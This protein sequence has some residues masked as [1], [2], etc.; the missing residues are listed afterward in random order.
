ARIM[1]YVYGGDGYRAG[2]A[3]V[4]SDLGLRDY[5]AQMAAQA[6]AQNAGLPT[7][8][9]ITNARGDLSGILGQYQ[10]LANDGMYRP[11]EQSA[12][13]SNRRQQVNNSTRAMQQNVNAMMQQRGVSGNAGINAAISMGG[14]FEGAGQRGNQ[15]ADL[16]RE[17]AQSRLTGME[18]VA[19]ISGQMAQ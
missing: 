12:I 7:A 5:F 15:Y 8:Q 1:A 3:G 19:G 14:Q 11:D 6:Q 2:A 9:Q 18:G 16:M 4:E 17:Q 13:L 10:G